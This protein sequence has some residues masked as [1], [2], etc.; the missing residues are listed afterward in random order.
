MNVYL[1]V[2]KAEK[3]DNKISYS[4]TQLAKIFL[5][6]SWA[7]KNNLPSFLE[8]FAGDMVTIYGEC[9]KP[10]SEKSLR[11][12][13]GQVPHSDIGSELELIKR[14]TNMLRGHHPLIY[15]NFERVYKHCTDKIRKAEETEAREAEA[16]EAKALEHQR[17]LESCKRREAHKRLS[18]G[19]W[20]KANGY[21][22]TSKTR[23]G[24]V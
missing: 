18:N 16:R 5:V 2:A 13:F 20:P 8:K 10:L 9:P 17:W 4:Q 22:R 19:E 11:E 6:C 24:F 14:L 12:F 1:R 7:Y 21:S 23:S 3:M 15:E